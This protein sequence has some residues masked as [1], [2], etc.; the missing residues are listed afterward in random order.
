MVFISLY[1]LIR[2]L[3]HTKSFQNL[4]FR[5]PSQIFDENGNISQEQKIVGYRI[6]VNGQPKGMV[7]AHKSRAMVEG[8]RL[9][10]EYKI[11]VVAIG[12]IGESLPSNAGN[13]K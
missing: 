9:Q 2:I 4:D 10:Q 13:K 7:K 3:S 12:T 6:Y 1:E 8:L 5:W 11:T